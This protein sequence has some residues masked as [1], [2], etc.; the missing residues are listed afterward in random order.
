MIERARAR[1]TNNHTD[2]LAFCPGMHVVM[3]LLHTPLPLQHKTALHH[4]AA[5]GH[6]GVIRVLLRARADAHAVDGRGSTALHYASYFGHDEAV[7]TLL[8][9]HA[10]IDVQDHEG[11]S[12]LHWAAL[13]GFSG[14]VAMLLDRGAD[15][16]LLE[17]NGNKFTPLDY[18]Q[19]ND[20]HDCEALLGARGAL[21]V[22]AFREMAAVSIQSHYR[23]Y[24]ARQRVRRLREE[25][26]RA[27]V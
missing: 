4:A 25:I 22:A 26:G 20:H 15:P 19:I 3:L 6:S 11:V 14:I 24:V 17:A 5:G 21:T 16:N 7:H 8:E 9:A 2:P 27:H 13:Q 23:G 12:P 10:V 18:A 1:V